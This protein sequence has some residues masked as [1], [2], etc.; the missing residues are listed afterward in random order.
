[1]SGLRVQKEGPQSQHRGDCGGWGVESAWQ[2]PNLRHHLIP[3]KGLG[4]GVFYSR[5]T[6]VKDDS[7]RGPGPCRPRGD[8][9]LS[10]PSQSPPTPHRPTPR[11]LPLSISI[12]PDHGGQAQNRDCGE[13]AA[14]K[15]VSVLSPDA[16]GLE[17]GGGQ[18]TGP[19]GELPVGRRVSHR[20]RV[21]PAGSHN[22]YTQDSHTGA[23][24]GMGLSPGWARG[25][26][27]EAQI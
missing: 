2:N 20:L 25:A 8:A 19:S 22:C 1:M 12:S 14:H 16:Q 18:C 26:C 21:E 3:K 11:C 13:Q 7:G 4:S 15:S 5:R 27:T 9:V 23:G 10:C 17:G 6:G 24:G